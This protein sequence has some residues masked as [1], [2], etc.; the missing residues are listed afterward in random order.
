LETVGF[1]SERVCVF[2]GEVCVVLGA[3]E[4][5]GGVVDFLDEGFLV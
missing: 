5:G 1:G 2:D 4:E 3:V